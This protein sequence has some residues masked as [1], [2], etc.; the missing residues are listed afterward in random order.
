MSMGIKTKAIH[1]GE[2][3]SVASRSSSP[4]LVMSSTFHVDDEV[5]F[6]ANELSVDT[7]PVY[8]RWGNPTIAQLEEKLAAL[9]GAEGAIAFATG[10]SATS[11]VM[12]GLLSQGDHIVISNTNY[13]GTAEVARHTLPRFGIH[14]TP[15]DTTDT[16]AVA[17]AIRPETRMIWVETPSNPLLNIAD[18][19]AI[20][21]IAQT[22]NVLL[23]VDSTFATPV[24]TRPLA[25][26]ADLVVHSLTKYIGG[27]GDAMGGA[28]CG[29]A[30]LLAPLRSEALAHFGGVISP[31]NAWLIMRGMA[32]LPI[33]MAEHATNALTV[34]RYLEDHARVE[35]V[36][37]PGLPSHPQ[38]ELAER[39]MDNLSGMV[40]FRVPEPR[41][42]A[43]RMMSEFNVIH[44]AVSL[45][46]HRSLMYLLQTDDLARNSYGLDGAALNAYRDVAG[47]GLFRFSVGIEDAEDIIADLDGVL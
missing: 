30:G 9:E 13:P 8:T 12:L 31:F 17:A 6:S 26:G 25:L 37:Y 33:R 15:V 40:S 5:S 18:I 29:S 42:T 10:M 46:H 24:A 38:A 32:T 39:Q 41:R 14:A 23:A 28:V 7:P 3:R 43:R 27:H 36:L 35:K 44:Y 11:S 22:N 45:G 16:D 21:G 1:V 2:R 4:D 47:D 20:S 34:A 19:T